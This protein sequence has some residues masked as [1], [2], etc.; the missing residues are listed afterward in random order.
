MAQV[1]LVPCESYDRS[2]CEEALTEVL[3][4]LGGLDR[5]KPGMCIVIK[6]NLVGAYEPEK[7]ATTHPTLLA[8]LTKLLKAREA[9][10]INPMA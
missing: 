7:A 4:Q 5:V 2:V 8:A 10:V 1:S 9:K 3:E 6:A